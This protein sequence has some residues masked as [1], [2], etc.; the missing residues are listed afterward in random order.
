M[1]EPDRED[2]DLGSRVARQVMNWHQV[3][4]GW[5]YSDEAELWCSGEDVP[6]M[7]CQAWR[8]EHDDTQA[9]QVLERMTALGFEWTL[10]GGAGGVSAEFRH[11]DGRRARAE[12]PDRRRALLR[13][14]LEA[15]GA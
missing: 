1:A 3:R 5:A 6:L 14:A 4:R 2:G 7:P 11:R 10:G 9:M 8:P 12:D 15:A 13:A